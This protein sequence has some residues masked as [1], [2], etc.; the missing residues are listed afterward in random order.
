MFTQEDL[1]VALKYF[2]QAVNNCWLPSIEK[3]KKG[4]VLRFINRDSG[5]KHGFG[6]IALSYPI[7]VRVMV[8]VKPG[9]FSMN[10]L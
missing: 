2:S 4:H 3:K 6:T 5:S 1:S 9:F 8:R 7:K 10:H